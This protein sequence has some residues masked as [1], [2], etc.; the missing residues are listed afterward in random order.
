MPYVPPH[1]RKVENRHKTIIVPKIGNNFVVFQ[2]A[3]MNP[4]TGRKNITFPGGG[5]KRHENQRNCAL[6]ELAEETGILVTR[7]KLNPLFYFKNANRNNYKNSNRNQGVSVTNHYHGFLA[8]LNSTFNNVTKT[9]KTSTL[10]N[11]EMNDVYL[12]SANNLYKSNRLWKFTKTALT[13]I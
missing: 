3:K 4:K 12:M 6:R 11:K 1:K 8:P 2:Y 10:R 13:F 5:C 9:F 7:N